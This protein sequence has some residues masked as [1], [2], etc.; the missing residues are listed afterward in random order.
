MQTQVAMFDFDGAPARGR[1]IRRIEHFEYPQ[2]GQCIC[3][4]GVTGLGRQKSAEEIEPGE[5]AI[6]W[7]CWWRELK[8]SP[9]RTPL[10]QPIRCVRDFPVL[11]T[12]V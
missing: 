4:H 10:A 5:S 3:R 7:R 6:A 8:A 2:G 11:C 9:R 1:G 12:D